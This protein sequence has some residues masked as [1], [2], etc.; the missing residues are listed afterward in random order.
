VGGGS[1]FFWRSAKKRSLSETMM[2]KGR[3]Y[4]PD[5]FDRKTIG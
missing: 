4:N 3:S 1:G 2:Q 5:S